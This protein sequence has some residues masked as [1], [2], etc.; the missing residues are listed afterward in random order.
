MVVLWLIA[1]S[2]PA[3]AIAEAQVP[4]LRPG[5]IVWAVD[6]AKRETRGVFRRTDPSSLTVDVDGSERRLDVASMVE[7]WRRGDSVMNG[8]II[9][10]LVGLGGGIVVGLVVGIP[11]ENEGGSTSEVLPWAAALGAGAGLGIG[12]GMDALVHG[13]TL[14][15]RRTPSKIVVAPRLSPSARAIQVALRF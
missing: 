6:D 15:Y 10:A 1:V 13:R 8:G 12:L 4:G 14:V 3:P 5:D 2:L 11:I 7:V 9:G